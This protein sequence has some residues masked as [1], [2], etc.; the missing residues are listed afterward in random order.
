MLSNTYKG[1]DV[2]FLYTNENFF[3]DPSTLSYY[4]DETELGNNLY[5]EV[6]NIQ[7]NEVVE[8]TVSVIY[9]PREQ[10]AELVALM[11]KKNVLRRIWGFVWNNL[12]CTKKGD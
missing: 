1:S 7:R 5:N 2:T 10:H 6:K 12:G 11:K 8:T 4:E 9:L 3:Y